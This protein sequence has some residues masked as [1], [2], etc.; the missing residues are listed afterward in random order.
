M[1][2]LLERSFVPNSQPKT[3][4]LV[5]PWDT[6][7]PQEEP[8]VKNDEMVI[9]LPKTGPGQS[10]RVSIDIIPSVEQ[11]NTVEFD[12][13]ALIS[14]VATH[15]AS[16][17]NLGMMKSNTTTTFSTSTP[18][19]GGIAMNKTST[20][21]HLLT[22]SV[23]W[24]ATGLFAGFLFSGSVFAPVTAATGLICGLIASIGL[25]YDSYSRSF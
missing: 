14:P 4:L 20:I 13:T 24:I 2:D 11:S 25:T 7:T 18:I 17:Y 3:N 12:D 8:T 21:F 5:G 19:F 10:I 6:S 22:N 23:S 16:S 15:L 9:K 1:E